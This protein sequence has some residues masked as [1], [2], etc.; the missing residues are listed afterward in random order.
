MVM[1]GALLKGVGGSW[2]MGKATRRKEKAERS[3]ISEA[4]AGDQHPID[5]KKWKLKMP[6][7]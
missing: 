3:N 7:L 4:T 2:E 6:K 5:Q 1:R